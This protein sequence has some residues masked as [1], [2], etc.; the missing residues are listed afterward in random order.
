MNSRTSFLIRLE[1]SLTPGGPIATIDLLLTK[2]EVAA[3]AQQLR[4]PST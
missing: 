1:V 2:K 4:L 3:Q